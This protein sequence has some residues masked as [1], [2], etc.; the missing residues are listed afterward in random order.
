VCEIE[1]FG[2]LSE[3]Q[4]VGNRA[5]DLQPEIFHFGSSKEKQAVRQWQ[6]LFLHRV[7]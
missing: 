4:I 7:C 5:E 1:S 6:G 3:F 2:R